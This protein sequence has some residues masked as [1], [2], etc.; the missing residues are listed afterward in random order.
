MKTAF[1]LS[2]SVI[3]EINL[4][5]RDLIAT[6]LVFLHS[7]SGGLALR[8]SIFIRELHFPSLHESASIEAYTIIWAGIRLGL[9]YIYI[10][11]CKLSLSLEGQPN[12]LGGAQH[13]R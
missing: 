13:K 1:I 5:M 9:I 11:K 8:N 10:Y 12:F 2:G 7:I 3:N 4:K 6:F